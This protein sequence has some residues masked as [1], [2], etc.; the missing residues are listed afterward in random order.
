MSI[1]AI[2]AFWFAMVAIAI[3][4]GVFAEKVLAARLGDYGSHLYK[5]IV[6]IT[7][8]FI[9]S[10]FYIAHYASPPLYPAAL[11]TGLLWLS[12]S[13]IFEF[14]FGHFVFGFPWEKLLADYSIWNGR[15]WSLVLASEVIAPLVN[16]WLASR[17]A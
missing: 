10:H 4:N 13:I 12:S 17:P 6:I 2:F 15:L 8:I 5:T 3:I 14:I 7:V 9:F 1:K 11:K 16:A